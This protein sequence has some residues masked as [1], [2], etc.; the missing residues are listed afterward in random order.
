MDFI[1]GVF[2]SDGFDGVDVFRFVTLGLEV[3]EEE[4]FFR[5]VINLSVRFLDGLMWFLEV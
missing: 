4:L 3:R 5:L 2:G 1:V